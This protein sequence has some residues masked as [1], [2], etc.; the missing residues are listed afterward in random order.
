[1]GILIINALLV[2]PAAAARNIA[3]SVKEYHVASVG[4]SLLSG[5]TGLILAYELGMAAGATIVVVASVL[6]FLTLAI[7]SRRRR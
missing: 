2:L 7:S 3:N 5:I 6:F 1:M 4:I